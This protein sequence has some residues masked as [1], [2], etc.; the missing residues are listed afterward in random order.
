MYSYTGNPLTTTPGIGD[1][2]SY[3]TIGSA[4]AGLSHISFW[5]TGDLG[6]DRP[7]GPFSPTSWSISNGAL[8]FSSSAPP[9]NL[10]STF[11]FAT[12]IAGEIIGY[13]VQIVGFEGGCGVSCYPTDTLWIIST[14]NSPLASS[15]VYDESSLCSPTGCDFLRAQDYRALS[16]SNPG[17]WTVADAPEPSSVPEPTT[18]ALMTLGLAG[19]G[20]SMRKGRA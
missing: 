12:N 6:S 8:N 19:L 16:F 5:M 17:E 18:L 4:P 13:N 10:I 1:P 15:I 9:P 11:D 14:V 20:R 3:M 7:Y 2:P